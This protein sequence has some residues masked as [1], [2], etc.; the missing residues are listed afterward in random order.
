MREE[1]NES[2]NVIKVQIFG[3]EYK[4]RGEADPEYIL[5]VARYVDSKM[6]EINEKLSVAS[7]G[8][9]AILAS[10]NLADELFK[11][12]REREQTLSQIRERAAGLALK[13]EEAV[14]GD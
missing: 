10:L 7:L 4:I 13:L 12:R 11:E 6:R 5:E 14:A 1:M 2:Q 8:K 3:G 9:V